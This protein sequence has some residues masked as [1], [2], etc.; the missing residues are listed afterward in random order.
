MGEYGLIFRIMV[1]K[2]MEN[3]G[4]TIAKHPQWGF[5]LPCPLITGII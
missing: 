5:I 3:Y 2:T 4:I 1:G